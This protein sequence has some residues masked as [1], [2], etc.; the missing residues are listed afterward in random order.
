MTAAAPGSAGDPSGA[1][2]LRQIGSALAHL[3]KTPGLRGLLAANLVL[4]MGVSFVMPF[5]SMF[6]TL[7]VGMSLSLFGVFMTVSAL[8]GIAIGTF[9]SHRSDTHL[10]RRSVLLMASFAGALGYLGYAFVREP[11]LLFAIG[12][13]VLGVASL[14]FS[15]LFAHARELVERSNV[16]RSDVPLFM[17]AFRM[18][19][20]LAWTV[21]PAVAAFT[22]EKFSFAGLFCGASL[23]YLGLFVLVF[24][25]V[26]ARPPRAP[27]PAGYPA[28]EPGA[29][30]AR[31]DVLLWFSGL[32]LMLAAHHMSVNNLSLLVLHEL[33]GS[34][35]QV[36]V[37]FSLAP[38]FELP[39]MLYV[40]LLAT[41]V[42][43]SKLVRG[44]ML[45][46][47]VYYLCLSVVETPAQIYPL[48]ALS[49]AIVSVTSGVAITFF[50]DLL[51][52]RLGAATNVYANAARIGSTS[53]YLTFGLVASRF[54]HRG[55]ALV[56][57]LFAVTALALSAF[58]GKAGRSRRAKRADGARALGEG[59]MR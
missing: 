42:R 53:G 49:A 51:P 8:F 54:G 34:E 13:G 30:L 29:V 52:Q 15:Q 16:K 21:G 7:E 59:R 57:A 25:F 20:A 31:R 5:M 58:A 4:G 35:R 12:G 28:L 33:G 2:A 6:C 41:R 48:Q 1:G 50:Q 14:T 43:S 44:A 38:I 47:A 17:N 18:V 55:T 37:I 9:L 3:L 56:C 45:L 24:L 40:G 27:A 32:T 26:E 39:F 46:A 10:S 11:W 22:L 36:G 19:F 23:L